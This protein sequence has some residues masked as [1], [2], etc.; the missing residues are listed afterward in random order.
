[1][2]VAPDFRVIGVEAARP[3]AVP[4]LRFELEASEPSGHEIFT[5]ALSAQIQLEPAKRSHDPATR[6]RLVELFGE[7][8]SW[9]ASSRALPWVRADVLVPAF[10][11]ATTFALDVPCSYD[12]EVAATKYL[13][14]LD[15]GEA[16]LTFHFNG[17]VLYRADDGRVQYVLLPWTTSAEFRLPIGVWQ[18]MMNAHYPGGRW[19]GLQADTLERLAGYR[20][21]HGLPTFDAAVA[22]LLG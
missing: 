8:G 17:T 2:T 5:V 11:G 22:Q 21:E 7:P 20:A 9:G 6:E 14:S 19:V 12:L 13:H 15:E 1:M 3:V 16:P 10:T 18:S 4:T